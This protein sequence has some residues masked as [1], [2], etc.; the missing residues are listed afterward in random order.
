MRALQQLQ[1]SNVLRTTWFNESANP[2]ALEEIFC[3]AKLF[4]LVALN[5]FDLRIEFTAYSADAIRS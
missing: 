2:R 4:F 1:S 3:N 5:L